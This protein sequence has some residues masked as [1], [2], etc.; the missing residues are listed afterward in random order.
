MIIKYTLGRIVDKEIEQKRS[1][2]T[3]HYLQVCLV[4]GVGSSINNKA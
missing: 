2:F 4:T 3:Q 1:D